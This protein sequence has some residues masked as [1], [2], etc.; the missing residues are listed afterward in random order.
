V[1]HDEPAV[2]WCHLNAE[3]DMLTKMIPDAR[4][5]SGSS[6]DEE[7]EETYRA[8]KS[9]ETRVLVIKPKLGAWGLNW[10]HCAHTVTFASHSYEQYFQSIRR[11]WRYGQTRPVRVDIVVTEGEQR[12]K[13]NMQRKARAADVMFT[14][15]LSHMQDAQ[16]VERVTT[17]SA[18]IRM[19]SWIA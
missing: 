4:Q 14:E 16:R 2:V 15:L 5:V 19:P 6:S 18:P 1:A 10:Q 8:F 17:H 11:F 7:K 9:G 12:I 13:A 3:G